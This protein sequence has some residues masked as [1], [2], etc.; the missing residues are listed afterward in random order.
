MVIYIYINRLKNDCVGFNYT[1]TCQF[2]YNLIY[3]FFIFN[4]EDET[5]NITV[6]KFVSR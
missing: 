5:V 3:W 4:F 6:N 1:L 2:L